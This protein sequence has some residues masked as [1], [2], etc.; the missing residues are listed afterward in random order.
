ML[1]H[2]NR[3]RVGSGTRWFGL[4]VACVAVQCAPA[5]APARAPNVLFISV[6]DLNDWVGCLGG[7]P[8]AHTPNIDRLAQRGV[9]FTRAYCAAPSCNPSRTS[10][11]TGVS[12][13]VSGVY[14]NDQPLRL[15]MPDVVT[16][17]QLFSRN[18]YHAMGA[19][20]VFHRADASSWDEYFPSKEVH[21]PADPL[22]DEIPMRGTFPG[23]DWGPLDVEPEEMSDEQVTRWAVER[24]GE[25]RAQPFFL[26]VGLFRPHLPWYLPREAFEAVSADDVA[27]PEVRED[28]L[29]DVPPLALKMARPLRYHRRMVAEGKWSEGVAAYLASV[30]YADGLVGRLLEALQSGPHAADTIVVLWGD[31]GW[32]LGEKTHWKKFTLWEEAARAP[33]VVFD[34]N[35]E[36]GVCQRTVNLMDLFP[37]LVDLCQLEADLPQELGGVTLRPLL[38]DPGAPWH[39]PSVTFQ[40]RARYSVRSER[41]RYTRFED[42]GEELYDHDADPQEF[43]NL[44]RDE[45]HGPIKEELSRWLPEGLGMYAPTAVDPETERAHEE[46]RRRQ[47]GPAGRKKGE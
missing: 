11:L 14:R 33:L 24:L 23:I 5:A 7:H 4:L 39:R 46:R 12:P 21:K 30:R 40:G 38:D 2:R 45:R 42:G 20:K 36:A 19:G 35:R 27:L 31:H 28:D 10:V 16:L 37:T 41:W 6:D 13:P 26:A 9:L 22:P 34:P 8:D 17:P 1:V 32:H 3:R 25:E 29:D 15:A 44:A 43:I 18:G 47:R